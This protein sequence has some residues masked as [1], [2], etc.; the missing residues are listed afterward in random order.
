M[1][2]T[3]TPKVTRENS[4]DFPASRDIPVDFHRIQISLSN[5]AE[6]RAH[7]LCGVPSVVQTYNPDTNPVLMS[8]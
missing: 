2:P 4:Q 3:K 8:K 5:G 1:K 6:D 7:S